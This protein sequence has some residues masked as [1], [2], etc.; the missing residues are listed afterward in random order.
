[1]LILMLMPEKVCWW[2]NTTK[3]FPFPSGCPA[4]W[5]QRCD[6][7]FRITFSKIPQKIITNNL[8]QSVQW[9]GS[10]IQRGNT[11]PAVFYLYE[12]CQFSRVFFLLRCGLKI[13]H[14]GTWELE[15]HVFL[16]SARYSSRNIFAASITLSQFATHVK[17]LIFSWWLLKNVTLIVIWT[18]STN[19]DP[20]QWKNTIEAKYQKSLQRCLNMLKPLFQEKFQWNPQKKLRQS[21]SW[22]L[23][24]QPV[25]IS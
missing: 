13:T 9:P 1:M 19:K 17:L 20:M 12:K 14:F 25:E 6:V 10:C 15:I 22:Y 18:V 21:A 5:F 24:R 8:K 11:S 23:S 7:I 4:K 16:R 2:L 3:F